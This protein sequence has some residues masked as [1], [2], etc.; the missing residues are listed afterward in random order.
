[1]ELKVVFYAI[2]TEFTGLRLNEQ[3]KSS[4]FDD[5][6]ERYRKLRKTVSQITMCQIGISTF[7]RDRKQNSL[8]T[9]KT[10]NIPIYPRSF[11][12]IDEKFVCQA[13][14]FQFLTRYKFDFNKFVYE[15]VSFLN[16]VQE[17]EVREHI[18]SKA[19]FTGLE[20][21]LD[22]FAIQK[23]CSRVA[24][25]LVSKEEEKTFTLKQTETEGMPMYVLSMELRGRFPSIWTTIDND[26]KLISIERIGL[27]ER[28]RFEEA[29]KALQWK[30]E[31]QLVLKM[32]G[33]TRVFRV[34]KQCKKPLL[35]HNMLM[36]LML[37]YDK[38]HRPLPV[39]YSEFKATLH[40]FFPWIYD[41]KH[42]ALRL[43]GKLEES[44]LL[45]NTSLSEL[46]TDI[47]SE[48]GRD[49]VIHPPAVVHAEG[50][51][52]YRDGFLPHEAGFDAYMCG[53]VFLRYA[54]IITFMDVKSSDVIPCMFRRYLQAME[55]YCNR[56][57]IIRARVNNINLDGADYKSQKPEFLF[58]KSRFM[59]KRLNI[60][61]LAKWFSPYGNV[62][63]KL[64]GKN[65]A[66][67]ATNSFKCSKD[68]L[69]AFKQHNSIFV[70]K[71][72]VWRHSPVV[73]GI[74]W[75]GVLISG[76]LCIWALLGTTDNKKP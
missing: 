9:A 23:I 5:G 29:E 74:L 35:G 42:V 3:V 10:F 13:S 76:G 63:L 22:E 62:D 66:L 68:I 18:A 39:S 56:I 25:W 72:S 14:S 50:F 37:M 73:R 60:D 40:A 51:D 55:D 16:E 57:N 54:H 75:S 24:D 49:L 6:A 34:M 7:T 32:L 48:K 43:R 21:D 71:Y 38:F 70:T 31:E 64:Y 26:G 17:R 52:R 65:Q 28:Q 30:Q 4:L 67:A 8:Y 36:D 20:R 2:D 46:Y 59:K 27:E 19:M 44:G 15:G 58:V 69:K 11:G 33:F 61:Q 1:M 41:T 45:Q 47:E 53:F 12:P